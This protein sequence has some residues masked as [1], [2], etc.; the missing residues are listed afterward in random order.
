MQ[1]SIA[2]QQSPSGWYAGWLGNVCRDRQLDFTAWLQMSSVSVALTVVTNS[3][4]HV[5]G[6]FQTMGECYQGREVW[7]C[8]G[9][10]GWECSELCFGT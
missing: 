8:V 4:I 1:N 3:L 7:L 10:C 5:T 9:Q 6:A 2:G